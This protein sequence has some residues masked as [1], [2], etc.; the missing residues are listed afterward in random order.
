VFQSA[1]NGPFVAIFVGTLGKLFEC[2]YLVYSVCVKKN[3]IWV[4]LM[5]FQWKIIPNICVRLLFQT[6]VRLE[7]GT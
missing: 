1:E 6:S 4:R 2:M 5:F 3:I 7:L